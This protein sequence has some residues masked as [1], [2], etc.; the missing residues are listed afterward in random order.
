MAQR[1]LSI[2]SLPCL[3]AMFATA[4]TSAA[5]AQAGNLVANPDFYDGL[6]GWSLV[7]GPAYGG[8][9]TLDESDGAPDAPSVHLASD[10]IPIVAIESSCIAIDDSAHVDLRALVSPEGG[11]VTVDVQPYSD[12]DCATPTDLFIGARRGYENSHWETMSL[13]DAA[14]PAG[15]QSAR[16]VLSAFY[17]YGTYGQAHFDH[18]AFGPTGTLPDGIEIAQEGLTGTWYDPATSGQ[19]FEFVVDGNEDGSG[20]LFGAW[21]TYS[22]HGDASEQRWYSLQ[23]TMP[24]GAT[25]ADFTIFRN[26]GGNFAAPP[27][28]N[29]LPVGTGTVKFSTCTLGLL[30]YAFDDGSSGGPIPIHRLMQNIE[31]DDGSA[32]PPSGT[33]PP[34]PSDFGY[35]GTW[36][37]PATS[38]QG[39]M[40]EINPG[41]AQAFFGWYTYAINGSADV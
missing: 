12:D 11:Y 36:Y 16:I 5:A 1:I 38:G 21:Y 3:I 37:D 39:F 34:P 32:P 30:T 41:N 14:L 26:I 8:T 35:S 13:T 33:T 19:G 4:S 10:Q 2:C 20:S 22:P 9:M 6:D 25:S 17:G 15:T 7:A 24:A 18:I 27:A 40:V 29:A 23:A 31:C 28:T